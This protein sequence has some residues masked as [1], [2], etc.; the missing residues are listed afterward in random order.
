MRPT[1]A[2]VTPSVSLS[3]PSKTSKKSSLL[4]CLG[5]TQSVSISDPGPWTPNRYE[6]KVKI[7]PPASF[8]ADSDKP[9]SMPTFRT[10]LLTRE[11]KRPRTISLDKGD[12]ECHESVSHR[13][14]PIRNIYGEWRQKCAQ[15]GEGRLMVWRRSQRA[16]K[17]SEHIVEEEKTEAKASQHLGSSADMGIWGANS[18]C[19]R[20]LFT[21]KCTLSSE[22]FHERN[23]NFLLLVRWFV[24]RNGR[25]DPEIPR[26]NWISCKC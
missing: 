3:I 22:L 14:M 10:K 25:C 26:K 7:L 1:E 21:F 16:V 9:R 18:P 15:W 24:S 11:A 17:M 20:L 5:T 23:G 19:F 12:G 6:P 4:T 2:S 13:M 8:A